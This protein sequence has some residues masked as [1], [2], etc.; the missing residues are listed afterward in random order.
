[1]PCQKSLCRDGETGSVVGVGFSATL[2]SCWK[3]TCNSSPGASV[4]VS[5]FKHEEEV[6]AELLAGSRHVLTATVT[7]VWFTVP[8]SAKDHK[9]PKEAGCPFLLCVVIETAGPGSH[10]FLSPPH[11]VTLET[12]LSPSK[13]QLPLC[14]VSLALAC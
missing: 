5:L 1:M 6:A 14:S 13:E 3:L 7:P 12:F 2:T 11:V 8:L 4:P 10:S 9:G